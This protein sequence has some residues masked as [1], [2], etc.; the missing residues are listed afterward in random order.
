MTLN[1]L[2][3]AA[4]AGLLAGLAA[5]PATAADLQVDVAGLRNADGL[6]RAAVCPEDTFTR[7]DCPHFGVAPATEG[8]VTVRDVPPGVYAV[9]VFH[10]EN[11]NG[12][13]DR[14]GFRPFEGL[15]FSND[16]PMRMG[17]PRFRDAAVRVT[18]DG[19]LTVNMRYYQ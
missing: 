2:A 10:D 9:Q 15:G 5:A 13:L 8:R 17:P 19:R 12:D 11:G 1:E 6:L 7:P 14:R 18:G 16:A 4:A 3:F